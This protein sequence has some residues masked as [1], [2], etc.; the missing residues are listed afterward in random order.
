MKSALDLE[1]GQT[2][3]MTEVAL[4][5]AMGFFSLMILT[6]VSMGA[7]E[8][9]ARPEIPDPAE[10]IS[11]VVVT[12]DQPARA[13]SAKPA[14]D[15]VFLIYWRGRFFDRAAQPV[16]P[17]SLDLTETA[18]LILAVDPAL[19]LG[20]VAGVRALLDQQDVIV[21]QL[22]EEWIDALKSGRA[23]P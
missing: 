7:G 2:N 16:D 22:N 1:S 8:G 9:A 14:P 3:A 18:R 20:D 19:P 6:L 4:A 13:G 11:S 17:A 12:A 23:S 15:D 5:L 10:A 21:A